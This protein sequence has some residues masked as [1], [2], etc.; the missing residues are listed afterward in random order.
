[1]KNIFRLY[2]YKDVETRSGDL[3]TYAFFTAE[4]IQEVYDFYDTSEEEFGYELLDNIDVL[5]YLEKLQE[6]G[7]TC[8]ELFNRLTEAKENLKN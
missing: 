7:E 8:R 1:M 4:T 2:F 3:G 6:T 5:K